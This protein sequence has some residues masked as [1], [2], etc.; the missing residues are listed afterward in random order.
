MHGLEGACRAGSLAGR[1]VKLLTLARAPAA[2]A[3][4]VWGI[5]VT[6]MLLPEGCGQASVV[7]CSSLGARRARGIG[8]GLSGVPG[9]AFLRC[10]YSCE[11]ARGLPPTTRRRR[12]QLAAEISLD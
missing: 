11:A 4:E 1:A 3:R 9:S 7:E 2:R 12:L 10:G 5:A 6:G 8:A